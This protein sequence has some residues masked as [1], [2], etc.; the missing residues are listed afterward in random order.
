[1]VC[2]F[3]GLSFL[4]ESENRVSGSTVVDPIESSAKSVLRPETVLISSIKTLS[5]SLNARV[6]H[7]KY[8]VEGL[9]L[10]QIARQFASSKSGVSS[11]LKRAKI[12]VRAPSLLH[13]HTPANLSL[14]HI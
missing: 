7:Q 5:D 3:R 8:V 4:A 1:M 13:G 10:K 14:I 2:D 12:P 11:A 6:L 9:S